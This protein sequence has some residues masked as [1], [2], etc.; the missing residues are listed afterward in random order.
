MTA[1][2]SPTARRRDYRAPGR[3]RAVH[4]DRCTVTLAKLQWEVAGTL[5]F[6]DVV[7]SSSSLRSPGR[8]RAQRR[9]S[10]RAAPWSRSRS[11]WRSSSCTSSATSTSRPRRRSR[12]WAKGMFKFVLHFLFLVAGV[13]LV[14][15][16]GQRFYWQTLGAFVGGLALNGLYG[17]MQLA[18]AESTGGE[19]RRALRPAGHRRRQPDQH[20]RRDRGAE[21][22]PG[23]R[24]HG[25]PEP[26][27]D[28]GRRADPPPA[29]DLPAD[30]A[31]QPAARAARPVAARSSRSSSSR[32]S[33]GAG[34]SG[35]LRARRAR[36]AVPPAAVHAAVP[37]AARGAR[38]AGPRRHRRAAVGVLRRCCSSVR[39]R[40]ARGLH[41]P[42]G[43]RLHPRRALAEPVLRARAQ[44]L[45]GLL[46]VHHRADE[47]RPALVLRRARSSRPGSSGASCSRPSSCTSSAGPARRGASASALAAAGDPLAARVRPLG[48]GLTAALVATLVSNFFYLTMTFYYFFVVALLAIAPPAVFA[49]D[50]TR[51]E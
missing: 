47:L 1:S 40:G 3:R 22:L 30:G 15:R 6:S 45:L 27:G 49:S 50:L 42:R 31:R 7:T 18:Y 20:L 51:R 4:R 8:D 24:A 5:S 37:R 26:P 9:A 39:D 16:R 21:R 44:Q 10:S 2:P 17:L 35:C 11:S 25:R 13:A 29:P 28:R 38:C 19:P 33:R 34:S 14:A 41:A 12:Q 48:W 43:L 23:Q 46:R 36:D 32:R